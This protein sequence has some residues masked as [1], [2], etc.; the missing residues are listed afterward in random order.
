MSRFL[1]PRFWQACLLMLGCMPGLAL[2]QPRP[3]LPS[4]AFYYGAQPPLADLQ[5]FDIAVV[6]PDFVAD[7]KAHARAPADGAHQLYAYVSLG[8]VHPSRSYYASL[9]AGSLR[10]SNEAWGS[11]VIDQTA[12][13]W[14]AF[15]LDTV[16]APLW[17]R[18]WRGFFMDTLDSYQLFATTDDARR[19]QQDAMIAIL[20]EFKRRYPE[21]KLILNRGFELLPQ[22]APL[23]SAVAAESLYQGYDVAANAYRPVT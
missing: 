23:V 8:E 18:G 16:I 1:L 13:G 2:P 15:F 11:R 3:S 20:K 5:A 10:G 6:E 12:P 14:Q 19:A 4:V 9:P 22:V 21:G 7:P 17:Q